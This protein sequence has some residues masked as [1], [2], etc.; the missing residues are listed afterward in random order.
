MDH[1]ELYEIYGIILLEY[2]EYMELYEP[3]D[4]WWLLKSSEMN[5]LLGFPVPIHL[6]LWPKVPTQI[7]ESG[8]TCQVL[9]TQRIA[10]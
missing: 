6:P 7:N 2:M 3:K 9:G 10:T 4:Q 1:M 8:G 5:P